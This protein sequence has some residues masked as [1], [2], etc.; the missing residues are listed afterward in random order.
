[1]TNL[2]KNLISE[3]LKFSENNENLS[4]SLLEMRENNKHLSY[5]NE[6]YL[7][8][9]IVLNKE[10]TKLYKNNKYQESQ[11]DSLRIIQ[12]QAK[13]LIASLMT[14]GDDFS[15]F[16]STLLESIE[17]IENTSEAMNIVLEKICCHRFDEI[18]LNGD[19]LITKEELITW[20]SKKNHKFRC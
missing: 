18:D 9:N 17:K 7:N 12:N 8:N 13:Q 3:N 16:N 19:G 4:L 6:D 2:N 1:M 10:I 14:A 5:L 11:I 20:A 15:N